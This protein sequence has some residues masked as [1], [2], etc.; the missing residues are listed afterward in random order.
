LVAFGNYQFLNDARAWD[1]DIWTGLIIGKVGVWFWMRTEID[2]AAKKINSKAWLGDLKDEPKAW[3]LQ[4]VDYTKYGAVRN[5]T[6]WVGLNGGS[7]NAAEGLSTVSFDDW[8]VYDAGGALTTAVDQN[9]KLTV[10]WGKIKNTP[11]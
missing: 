9:G 10:T 7:G 3:M 6:K 1:N 4:V 2:A 11:F 8:Y 5:P